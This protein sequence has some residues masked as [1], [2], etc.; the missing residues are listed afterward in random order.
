MIAFLVSVSF[1]QEK[2]LLVIGTTSER[3]ILEE[4]GLL[5][6]FNVH[7]EVPKL[8]PNDMREVKLDF[9]SLTHM[10][11]FSPLTARFASGGK[12]IQ[13]RDRTRNRKTRLLLLNGQKGERSLGS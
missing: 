2:K 12:E 10:S 7:L 5:E 9:F 4:M 3:D 11:D 1:W 8:R 13:A 6:S